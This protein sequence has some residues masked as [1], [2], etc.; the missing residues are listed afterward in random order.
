MEAHVFVVKSSFQEFSSVANSLIS[1]YSKCGSIT[2]ACK[3]FRLTREPDL[4]TWTSLINAY[5]FHGLAKEAI[6]VFEKMLSCGVIPDRISFLGVLSACSH[7]GLVTKG[8]HYFNLMT[9]VYKIVPDSGQ[10]TCL[11]DLLGRR[12][13]INEAFEFLRSMPMEAESNTLGAFIGSCNLHENI[14]MAKWAAEK[15]FIKEPEKNVN[16]AVM[17]NI[18]ASHRHWYDVEGV[19]RMMGNKC[20][21]RVPGC[22]W[23][24]ISNQV[25]SFVSN[26]KTHLK[27]LE[28]YATLKMLLWPMKEKSGMNS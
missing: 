4:V 16:Y 25:H 3:C 9:S 11:V 6:E 10:Y 28:M 23:I 15:L 12:G 5:A 26:D 17:S 22:S 20:D 24:E 8:L 7:C 19:R 14:G 21:A 1:A 18:Y 2:S 13:L 27:A